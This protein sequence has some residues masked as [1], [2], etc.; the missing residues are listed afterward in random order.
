DPP[1]PRDGHRRSHS[2]SSP[3]LAAI[4]ATNPQ[5]ESRLSSGYSASTF[6]SSLNQP[7]KGPYDMRNSN[8]VEG[9]TSFWG[10]LAK[11]AKALV[12]DD[13]PFEDTQKT[14]PNPST[15]GPYYPQYQPSNNSIKVDNPVLRKRLDEFASSLNQIGGR[16]GNA[17][18]EGRTIVENKTADIIQETKKLQIRRNAMNFN[19]QNYGGGLQSPWK[20]LNKPTE[21]HMTN[22]PE[23]RLKAA[24][25][26]ALATAAKAKVL[27][28]ELKTVK[29]DL[30]FAKARCSQLEDENKALR[31]ACEKGGGN[32]ADD[33]M[34]RDQLETLLAEK[35]RLAHENSVY[36]RENRFLMEIVEFH[37]LTMQDVVY[38]DEG[39]EEVTEVYP[40]S[41]MSS[42]LSSSPSSPPSSH[43][44]M[45]LSRSASLKKENK[46]SSK[47]AQNESNDYQQKKSPQTS[48][49]SPR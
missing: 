43:D 47:S 29:A 26:V 38:L 41:G 31:E 3:S 5:R 49:R 6:H 15:N 32:R 20:N 36:A 12:D 9:S 18:E 13:E 16:I 11:K 21:Q 4:N 14:Y 23:D 19:D 39:I 17:F 22:S 40:M 44:E 37:Q 27:L 35:T 7:S 48:K 34:I 42:V 1:N 46:S 30:A 2:F 33:D 25:D 28:R 24:R 10:V 45:S 8:E